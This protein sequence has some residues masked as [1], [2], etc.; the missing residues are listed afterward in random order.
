MET[1]EIKC[2]KSI[3]NVAKRAKNGKKRYISGFRARSGARGRWFKSRHYDQK[4]DIAFA[5]SVF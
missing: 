5:I 3:L 2:L 4:T 1:V